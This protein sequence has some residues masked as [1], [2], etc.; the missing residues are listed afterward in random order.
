MEKV[1]TK[2]WSQLPRDLLVSITNCFGAFEDIVSFSSVCSS[3]RS[4]LLREQQQNC[5][6]RCVPWLFLNEPDDF[7]IPT[8]NKENNKYR[9]KEPLITNAKHCWG[10]SIGWVFTLANDNT[11]ALINP[12]TRV[13]TTLPPLT[14]SIS[15]ALVFAD[16]NN[17][18]TVMVISD[19]QDRLK[20]AFARPGFG[21]WI[22]LQDNEN[23]GLQQGQDFR[24][25]CQWGSRDV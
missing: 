14:K 21:E 15:R 23:G 10:S 1:E 3:W 17:N 4:A 16:N 6:K 2:D 25:S 18:I 22:T 8:M 19:H 7:W 12:L 11:T 24:G 13:R 20:L 5:S 9:V